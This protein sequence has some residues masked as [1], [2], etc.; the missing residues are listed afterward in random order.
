MASSQ[1]M[2]MSAE[3]H[4]DHSD[5][6]STPTPTPRSST[7]KTKSYAFAVNSSPANLFTYTQNGQPAG[8]L[9]NI[10]SVNATNIN[11]KKRKI[12]GSP[13]KSRKQPEKPNPNTDT[14]E[15]DLNTTYKAAKKALW[16]VLSG[17]TPEAKMEVRQAMYHLDKALNQ[18]TA[19]NPL[20]T[21]LQQLNAKMDTLLRKQ[22]LTAQS[23]K[24]QKSLQNQAVTAATIA[25][26]A[27]AALGAN[28]ATAAKNPGISVQK[29]WAQKA[30]VTGLEDTAWIK[31]TA[32]AAKP[33][34]KV[35]A[36]SVYR[37]RQL[38]LTPKTA[39]TSINSIAY[40]NT[41]NNAL[42][43]AKIN[44]VLVS[45]VAVSRTGASIVVTTA[46]GNTAEDLLKHKAL[47]EPELD[48][49]QIKKNNKWH[50]IL[51][52]G[53]LT[54]VFNT[55]DGLEMLQEEVE[56]FNKGIKLVTKPVWLSTAENRQNKMHASAIISVATQEE[57]QNAL[58]TRVV[59]AGIADLDIHI[60]N[61]ST[62]PGA[63][64]VQE[65]TTPEVTPALS[66]KKAKKS[67]H[68]Q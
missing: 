7:N 21:Q 13:P 29:T 9:F 40:R 57:A 28:T 36:E 53:L 47:W 23:V 15:E 46:E 25:T 22:D 39:V 17:V 45:T 3:E 61:V 42:K 16:K 41:I 8:K 31:V 20:Q 33:N 18:T 27:T 52:H 12:A 54:A 11:G 14:E 24:I 32:K 68:I 6:M 66:A 38:L 49:A 59:V 4:T 34:P 35:T 43:Q 58:R 44:N 5:Q 55:R 63:K 1:S 64:Y 26:S 37:G 10:T 56:L 51:L 30:A 62:H 19:E 48:L 50:K 2:D 60:K 67:V 65:T